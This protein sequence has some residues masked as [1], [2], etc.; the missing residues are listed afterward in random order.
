MLTGELEHCRI[1]TNNEQFETVQ[2]KVKCD[3]VVTVRKSF[4]ER[5]EEK[6]ISDRCCLA[7]GGLVSSSH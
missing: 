7:L 2:H 4:L 6:R 5:R 3:N 1:H